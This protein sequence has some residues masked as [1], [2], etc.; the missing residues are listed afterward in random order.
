MKKLILASLLITSIVTAR[1]QTVAATNSITYAFCST[2]SATSST[3][4][5]TLN[6]TL[7]AA[8]GY[9][10][11]KWAYVSGPNTP[12]LGNP[13]NTFTNSTIEQSAITIHG[14][15]KGAYVFSA[16]GVSVGGLSYT[17]KSNVLVTAPPA[18]RKVVSMALQ[19][20]NGVLV[21]AF[22]FDDGSTQ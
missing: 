8:D 6:A 2:P 19:L 11:I 4:S 13:V 5:A 15:I 10:Q 20:V 17:L 16:T 21:P 1:S 12:I 22:K 9:S 3:D 18:P 14:M 7:V